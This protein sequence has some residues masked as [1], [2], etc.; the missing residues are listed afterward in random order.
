MASSS[1]QPFS[2][3]KDSN[4]N[5]NTSIF[6]RYDNN[7]SVEMLPEEDEMLQI[8]N[9]VILRNVVEDDVENAPNVDA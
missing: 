3:T 9:N 1:C 7:M 2:N 6:T 5:V 4:P 8:P